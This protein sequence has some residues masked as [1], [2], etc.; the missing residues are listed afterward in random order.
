[1]KRA[2]RTDANAFRVRVLFS[3]AVLAL[4]AGALLARAVELQLVDHSFLVSKGDA[5]S[6]R[7]VK[8]LAHRGNIL[9]RNGE[10]L[11]VSTPVES[12]TANP[13]EMASASDEWPKLAR[14]LNRNRG[15]FVRRIS[16]SQD[17]DF[18]YLA[19]HLPPA[20]AQA[21]RKLDVPGVNLVREYRRYYP[22]GEVVGHVLGFTSIDDEGQE[23]AELAYDHW[24]AGEDGAK[25]VIQDRLGRKVQDVENI[26]TARPGRD[27]HLSLDMRIQYLAYRE[28]KSA[29]I[30]NRARSGSMVVLDVTTGEVLAMVNQPTFNANDR[31]Q[32]KASAYRNRAATDIIEPGSSIKPFVVAAALQSG[33]YDA[34]SIVDTSPG[35]VK[36]GSKVIEDE[37]P[38]GAIGLSDILAKSSNVG[39]TKIALSLEPQ[40]IWST[41]THLGFGQVTTSG[42]PGESAGVLSNYSNWRPVGIA[43]LSYG[44]GL[45]VTPLQLVHAYA[46]LGALGI[47]RPVSMTR[48]ENAVPGERVLTEHNART[49][50]SLLEAVVNQ[51]GT[52][53]RAVIPGY[54][55]AGKTG[56]AWKASA[57]GYSTDHYVGVFGGVAPA[58]HP[59]LAAIVVI[60]DPSAGKY[61]GGD[62]AAPVFSAVVGGALRMM[63]V[64]P[65]AAPKSTDETLGAAP[66]LVRR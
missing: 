27:L 11:A 45:S 64:A 60:D 42:F 54:R 25:R 21:V 63:G 40:I 32:I 6:M 33:R 59:R 57:G 65:D 50:I 2:P 1:M 51:G 30:E 41:L 14:A 15:E 16:S 13:K 55:V 7:T 46:T 26:R 48:V 17:R 9:D 53:T 35:F 23:G 10:P 44:Y 34:A 12:V 31:D 43:T 22:S 3:F 61:Y 38:Q 47:S 37:H 5:R 49:L 58:T 66:A 36:V 56:T 62:V 52:G 24:L 18:I 4:G 39:M 8:T 20:S 29:I 19:R 28:L